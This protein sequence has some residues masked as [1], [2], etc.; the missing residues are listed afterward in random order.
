M[1]Y[2]VFLEHFSLVFQKGS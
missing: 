1:H 2:A